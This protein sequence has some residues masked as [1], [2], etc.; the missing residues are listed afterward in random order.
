MTPTEAQGRT[1][2]GVAREA[3]RHGLEHGAPPIV[4]AGAFEAPLSE[5]GSSFVT[6]HLGGALRGCIGS[7][8]AHQ[9]LVCDVA[10]HA[11]GA[12]FGDRRFQPLGSAEL[13]AVHLHLS[14]LSP[15]EPVIYASEHALLSMLSPGIHGLLIELDGARATFLPTVWRSIPQGP[16][17]LEQLKR[18]AGL[19]PHANGY[20]AWRYTTVEFSEES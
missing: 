10:Q 5:P 18:K 3:I 14:I 13:A 17:F 8:Q 4:D 1:L 7:L 9:P 20:R 19:E 16:A 11:Y 6:L 12:A 2:L 15:L